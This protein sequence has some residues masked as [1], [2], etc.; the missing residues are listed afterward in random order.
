MWRG[1]SASLTS[2][3][4]C[5]TDERR[6]FFHQRGRSESL[7]AVPWDFWRG[8]FCFQSLSVCQELQSNTFLWCVSFLRK[9]ES[10]PSEWTESRQEVCTWSGLRVPLML[11]CVYLYMIGLSFHL[12]HTH[13]HTYTS[14]FKPWMAQSLIASGLSSSQPAQPFRGSNSS[15]HTTPSI[16]L[17]P[18]PQLF[19]PSQDKFNLEVRSW[20]LM[21][22]G[23]SIRD[24]RGGRKLDASFHLHTHPYPVN[25]LH[26][27]TKT[28]FFFPFATFTATSQMRE[29][30]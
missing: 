26:P 30:K 6:I 9:E 23:D 28:C 5:K 18:N 4:R 17:P 21:K 29:G 10:I 11:Y 8:C 16:H 25:S 7:T 2:E 27:Q 3:R 1:M 24:E 20:G 22:P 12:P 15:L 13:K 19:T 14:L